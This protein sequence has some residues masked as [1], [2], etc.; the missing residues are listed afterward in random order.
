MLSEKDKKTVGD[1]ECENT[2]YLLNM[3]QLNQLFHFHFHP[4]TCTELLNKK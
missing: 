3:L 2:T 1:E 4:R